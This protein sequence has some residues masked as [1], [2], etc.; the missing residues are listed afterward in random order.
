MEEKRFWNEKRYYSLDYYLKSTFGEKVYKVSLQ[1]GMTCPNRDGKLDTR[2]CSFCSAGGSGDFAA[3][4]CESV[5]KQI[6]LAI[7]GIKQAKRVGDKF[8]A[9]FQ[10][11][12]NTY[13][14]VAY[15]RKIF[16][17][18]ISHPSIVALSIATR[19]DC[20]GEDVLQL[21]WELNQIKP[22]WVELGLQTIHERTAAFI[23]RGYPLSVFEQAVKQ[24]TQINVQVIVHTI[25]G[26]P[27][28]SK[29]DMIDTIQYLAQFSA[30][31]QQEKK[32]KAVIQ[33]IK[34]QL[35]HVLAGTD[36]AKYRSY[37]KTLTLEQ[38]V[39]LVLEC[40]EQ[41]PQDI[42]IHRITGDGPKKILL[43]PEWSA[44]KKTVMNTI[45]REMKLQD[46]WQGKKVV[47]K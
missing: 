37:F 5:T 46:S 27:F 38:Y 6:D 42:V 24:L 33:G 18:A 11:Y 40:I 32:E 35:L 47:I 31:R 7:A 26:L 10:S 45:H 41:L 39:N 1:G 14:E 22:V 12:T 34:L 30:S 2:G 43:A 13:A 28:E 17:E 21:L 19:P 20:L 16:T 25:L 23:R 29:N 9:Y 8:I 36:L 15:L 4:V 3:P 44:S